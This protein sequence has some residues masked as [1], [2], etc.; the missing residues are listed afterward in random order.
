MEPTIEERL[1]ALESRIRELDNRTSAM[2]TQ[3]DV[4]EQALAAA[5]I[6]EQNKQKLDRM[7]DRLAAALRGFN[8]LSC[9]VTGAIL[10]WF[11]DA[12]LQ[13]KTPLNDD[14]GRWLMIAG[15]GCAVYAVLVITHQEE[16]LLRSLESII[17][18]YRRDND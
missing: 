7:G 14:I 4:M 3:V 17:P 8:A 15:G 13:D 11:G 16:W 12:R 10:L 6:A 1:T 18:W 9:G 2:D 5:A